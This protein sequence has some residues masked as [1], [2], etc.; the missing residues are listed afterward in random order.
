[1]IIYKSKFLEVNYL[2]VQ[3]LKHFLFS[4]FS[5]YMDKE[6]LYHE[7][8]NFLSGRIHK[9]S[10]LFYMDMRHV[11]H[12]TDKRLLDWFNTHILPRMASFNARKTAWLFQNDKFHLDT[13]FRL[14]EN[15]II[16]QKSF[17]DPQKLMDWLKE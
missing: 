10:R 16:H 15:L 1:M 9:R 7:F 11:E 17:R 5:A 8:L 12:L 14:N 3:H 6:G 2:E 4:P 13:Q